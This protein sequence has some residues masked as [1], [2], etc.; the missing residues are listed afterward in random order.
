MISI[1]SRTAR[2]LRTLLQD[3]GHKHVLISVKGGGCNGLQYNIQPDSSESQKHDEN[4]TLH[5]V[6][7]RICGKSLFYLLGTKIQWA[8]DAM[9]SRMEFTNPNAASSCGC[10]ETFNV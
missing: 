6:P 10:G 3:T 2:H 7:L 9:G 8:D 5:K 4:L 1:C